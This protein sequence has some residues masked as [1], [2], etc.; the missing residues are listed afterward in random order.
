MLA[1]HRGRIFRRA[2]FVQPAEVTATH[3]VRLGRQTHITRGAAGGAHSHVEPDVILQGHGGLVSEPVHIASVTAHANL[4]VFGANKLTVYTKLDPVLGNLNFVVCRVQNCEA[5]RSDTLAKKTSF[6]PMISA[7]KSR[8][9]VHVQT[10]TKYPC[11]KM[12]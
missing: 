5:G 12:V 9:N 4:S 3:A 8:P 1:Q 11:G 2:H 7:P 10:V 6:V